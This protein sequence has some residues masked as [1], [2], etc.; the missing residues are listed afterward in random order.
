MVGCGYRRDHGAHPSSY[1]S[2]RKVSREDTFLIGMALSGLS[3]LMLALTA[4]FLAAGLLAFTIFF[5]VVVYTMFL[6]RRTPQ[7][8]VIGGAAGA[9]PPMIGWAVAT[10]GIAVESLLM[11]LLIFIWTP[12]HF[13]ALALFTND[14]YS[15]AGVP[16]MTVARGEIATR[17]Q[18]LW[19]ALALAPVCF[20]I[21]FSG[22]GGPVF[23]V[24]SLALNAMF[25]RGAVRVFNRRDADSKADKWLAEKRYFFLS[26]VY[27]F[28]LFAAIAL[29][30]VLAA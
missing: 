23:L 1:D 26:L 14:D 12:P 5:Y 9:L 11:F 18:I 16:M 2:F 22:I 7:N 27:L 30:A 4:N 25:I 10:G 6:K 21:A 15:R 17:Q 29:D 13:W 19:Y 20:L 28:V 3:V 8:I 24:A